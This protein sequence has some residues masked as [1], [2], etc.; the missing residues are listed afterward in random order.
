MFSR[1]IKF[2]TQSEIFFTLFLQFVDQ[3]VD[4]FIDQFVDQFVVQFVDK[5]LKTDN[6]LECLLISIVSDKWIECSTI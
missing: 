4:Q 1:C 2:N 5:L 6:F 3:S